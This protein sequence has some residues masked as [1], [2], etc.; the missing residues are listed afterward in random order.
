MEKQRHKAICA[1]KRCTKP[2]DCNGAMLVQISNENLELY[3]HIVVWEISGSVVQSSWGHISQTFHR[4][5]LAHLSCSSLHQCGDTGAVVSG[6]AHS[7]LRKC[8]PNPE[9]NIDTWLRGSGN[10][11]L[12]WSNYRQDS[13]S[14]FDDVIWA[15][16]WLVAWHTITVV[17]YFVKWAG[18]ALDTWSVLPDVV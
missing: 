10:A 9:L 13:R 12:L 15:W 11:Q 5:I 17:M 14:E 18:P 8:N 16:I 2:E 1:T 7:R 3:Q 4:F 6:L